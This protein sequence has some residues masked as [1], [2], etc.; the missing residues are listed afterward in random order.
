MVRALLLLAGL[1]W[2]LP[3]GT[4]WAARIVAV[5]DV[6][7]EIEGFDSVLR[8]AAL[9]DQDGN[10]VGGDAILV[11]TGDLTDRGPR[12]R[13]VM[14]RLRS[15]QEQAPSRGGRVVGLL[16][17]HEI[18]N[19]ANLF[20]EQS[21]PAR[22]YREIWSDFAGTDAGRRQ[23]AGY[24]KWRGWQKR[25]P[26]CV[27][28][29]NRAWIDDRG[30]WFEDH[31][32]G[33]VEYIEA[34][35]PAGEYGS[36]LRGLGLVV[37]IEG[38][39]FLHGGISP[40]LVEQGY[41][42]VAAINEAGRLAIEQFDQDRQRLLDEAV[43]LPFS[44]LWEMYCSLFVEMARLEHDG[45]AAALERRADLAELNARLPGM[46]GW[47]PTE[48]SG[49]LWYRG[50]ANAGE[51][52]LAPELEGVLEAFGAKRIAVGHTPQPGDIR[53]RFDGRVYL[54]DTAMAYAE[55]GGRAAALE[56]DGDRVTA[57][58][59][60]ERVPLAGGAAPTPDVGK[61]P[62][63]PV[64][65]SNG[66]GDEPVESTNGH[67]DPAAAAA[68]GSDEVETTASLPAEP[69]WIGPDGKPLPFA[70]VD[71]V[72]DFLATAKVVKTSGIETGVT[73]PRKLLLERDGVR[74]HAIFHTVSIEK[75]RERL[76]G[77]RV[78]NF[79]RDHYANNVAAFE[80][81]RMLGMTNVP[82]AVVRRVG[83]DKGSVQLWIESSQTE[84]DRRQ[85][86]LAPPGDW[87]LTAKDMLVF[88]NLA[89]NIDRNQGNILYDSDW[90]LWFID[91]TRTF[92]RMKQLP[93]PERIGRCSR[94]LF[95]ALRGLDETEVR[96]RL[97]PY[98]GGY[99]I[100][101]LMARR[102]TLVA[103]IEERIATTHEMA[104][105]AISRPASPWSSGLEKKKP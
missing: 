17:N 14:D 83:R 71:E 78:V 47:F 19:L 85:K 1:I 5:G 8:A 46:S 41:R 92:G 40:A 63:D 66:H 68:T 30:A 23:K 2:L 101:G 37:E 51:T 99:E 89:N 9:M 67:Q 29:G 90:N 62:P 98:L 104:V 91:H 16:G 28:E 32:P 103:L 105:L 70:E 38:S 59:A 52:D 21:T 69:V 34:L 36:W 94:R 22:V 55:L 81:S 58:Y 84:S 54:I 27:K 97:E 77:G 61:A 65:G 95:Q 35:S 96:R 31:P 48:E 6:H 64:E 73:L 20:D 43:I 75:R 11:Q 3:Q 79:F 72:L 56:I 33:Y 82:P 26:G 49:P 102:D 42:S 24:K 25:Y 39:V 15:L 57:I 60:D 50:L 74:A 93:S 10:W 76:H 45:G 12:V 53:S 80:L 44:S 18:S 100:G 88:D 87:R 4:A 13:A 86:K 7:G